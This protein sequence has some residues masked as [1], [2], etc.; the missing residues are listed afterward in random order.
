M[1]EECWW[2]TPAGEHEVAATHL[3]TL[4]RSCGHPVPY[5]P[6]IPTCRDHARKLLTRRVTGHPMCQLCD[7]ALTDEVVVDSRLVSQ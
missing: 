3:L 4:R 5:G 7:W 6:D 2:A 1:I